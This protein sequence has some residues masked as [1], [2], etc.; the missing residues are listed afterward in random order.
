MMRTSTVTRLRSPVSGV[1]F[2]W[3]LVV[4][5]I[6]EPLRYRGEGRIRLSPL[7]KASDDV[8]TDSAA[9]PR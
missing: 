2:R 6:G 4:T 9:R 3:G 8:P 7:E 5:R 1:R